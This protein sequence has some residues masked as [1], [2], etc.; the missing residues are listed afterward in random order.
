[1]KK[2]VSL[3]IVFFLSLPSAEAIAAGKPLRV[4]TSFL[5]MYL[6]TKNTVG[7]APGVSVDM[8]LPASL[9]CPHDYALVPSDM[10]KIAAA[11]LF[12]VNGKGMEEFLGAPVRKANPKV[13]M[14]DTSAGVTPLRN[15]DGEEHGEFNPHTWVSPRNAVLQ[16]R[17]IEQALSK[18]SPENRDIF[19]RNADAYVKR[20]EGLTA[21]FDQAA[22]RFRNRNI[23]TFHN[24]F[25]YLARDAGLTIV[26]E[27]E[28]VPGQEPSA[29]E[30]H[31]LIET[32]RA[33]KAAAVFG[34]PQYPARLA[35]MVAREAGVPV[36]NLDPVATG[37]TS[38]TTYE[39]VMRDNL[40]VLQEVLG[41]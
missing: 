32:I 38:L 1:M 15:E 24:V 16:V 25:D 7:S 18:A 17:A 5:P 26:G 29:G 20:L 27:I 14:V 4:L 8:M 6:F 3:W 40:R 10:K 13:A 21:E 31:K 28:A 23:V 11:D 35:G 19:R 33:K 2:F 36:R 34:E 30:I 37:S 22:K 39:D 9:G 12:I 41:K